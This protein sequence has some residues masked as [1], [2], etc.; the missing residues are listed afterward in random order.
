MGSSRLAAQ[1]SPL[2]R[3]LTE[4]IIWLTD[5]RSRV[6][7]VSDCYCL[8]RNEGLSAVLL[9]LEAVQ[10]VICDLVYCN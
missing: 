10:C 1:P 2:T 8:G 7:T 3:G 5:N 9:L 6:G 4:D